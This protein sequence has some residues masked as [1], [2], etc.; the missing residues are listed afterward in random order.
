MSEALG[1][2][3]HAELEQDAE[4]CERHL[5][6]QSLGS[7][8]SLCHGD[9]GNLMCLLKFYRDTNNE[10]GIAKVKCALSQVAHNFFNEDFLDEHTIPD[11]GMMLGITGVGQALLHAVDAGLPDVLALDF[12]RSTD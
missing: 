7:G 1:A 5:W 8:Y 10:Q 12:A 4:R 11:L 6:E 2:A 9:F 3:T